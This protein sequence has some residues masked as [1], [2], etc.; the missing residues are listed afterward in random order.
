LIPL[1]LESLLTALHG[2][3]TEENPQPAPARNRTAGFSFAVVSGYVVGVAGFY[4]NFFGTLLQATAGLIDVLGTIFLIWLAVRY[5]RRR[6]PVA[7]RMAL[8]LTGVGLLLMGGITYA[9]VFPPGTPAPGSDETCVYD[10]S[11]GA[12]IPLRPSGLIKQKLPVRAKRVFAVSLIIGLDRSTANPSSPHP[13]DV[14][15]TNAAN[16]STML[17]HQPD[18]RDNR[19]TRFNFPRVLSPGSETTTLTVEVINK[20]NEQIGVY[21]KAP[22]DGDIVPAGLSG[23]TIRGHAGQEAPYRRTDW[24]LAGCIAGSL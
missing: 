18:I 15:I 3:S 7:R 1:R 17:L 8:T 5:R 24:T 16:G 12:S 22:D 14:R 19:L 20:S 2:G 11:A 10:V 23:V 21:V 4:T 6:P 9:A 13:V